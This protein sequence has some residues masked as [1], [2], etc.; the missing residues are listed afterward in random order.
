MNEREKM[1]NPIIIFITCTFRRFLCVGVSFPKVAFV[2]FHLHLIDADLTL[3]VFQAEMLSC[4][5][6]KITLQFSIQVSQ[7]AMSVIVRQ[8]AQ[9]QDPVTDAPI[10]NCGIN[11]LSC[12]CT[13]LIT[14]GLTCMGSAFWLSGDNYLYFN[15]LVGKLK[16]M[17]K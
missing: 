6:S 11:T 17:T 1:Y 4:P 8:H 9:Y 12:Q 3:L 7:Q 5:I 16:D 14:E 10:C 15:V 2:L 13:N